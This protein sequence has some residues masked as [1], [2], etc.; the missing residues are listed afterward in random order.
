MPGYVGS[1]EF[2]APSFCF[3]CG[4]AFPWTVESTNAA[5]ALVL[6]SEGLSDEERESLATAIGELVRETP[7]T[8]V[9]AVRFKKLITKVGRGSADAFRAV[10]VDVVS[11]ATRKAI[12]G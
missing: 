2:K 12:W 1:A 5:K 11:E 7:M 8:A 4:Q 3:T 10:L 6:E 9:A